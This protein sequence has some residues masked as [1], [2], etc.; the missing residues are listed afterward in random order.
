[1]YRYE[2]LEIGIPIKKELANEELKAFYDGEE[3]F[4]ECREY[5]GYYGANVLIRVVSENE[6]K[7]YDEY[8][9]DGSIEYNNLNENGVLLVNSGVKRVISGTSQAGLN[10]MNRESDNMLYLLK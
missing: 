7:L 1:M 3:E 4:N 9:V 6:L 2:S 5:N 10:A 8:L